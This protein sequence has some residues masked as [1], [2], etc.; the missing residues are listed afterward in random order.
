MRIKIKSISLMILCLFLVLAITLFFCKNVAVPV[1]SVPNISQKIIIDAGHGGFDGGAVATD[2][3]SEKDINLTIALSLGEMLSTF[4]YDV[5]YTRTFDTGTEDDSDL[6][7]SKR[8]VSD[9]NNRL[10]I[11][12][13]N[14]DAIFVS[15]HLNKF[16]TTTVNGAQVFYSDNNAQSKDLGVSIQNSIVSLLQ[17]ENKRVVKKSDSSTFLLKKATIPAVIVEC[18]FISNTKELELL[19]DEKYQRKMAFSVF[20]GIKEYE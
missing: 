3:T 6:S 18:G 8:K 7:I 13:D 10:K 16:T 17:K 19:K 2:G 15:I 12:E 20:L 4:G 5:I 11:M 14:A 9:L 1:L